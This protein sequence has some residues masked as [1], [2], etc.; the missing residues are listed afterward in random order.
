[1]A[2]V[3]FPSPQSGAHALATD[4]EDDDPSAPGVKMSFLEHLDELRKRIVN[5]VHRDCGLRRGRV[6]LHQPDLSTS[7]W[8]RRA[9]RCPPGVKLIYTQPGEA[10]SLYVQIAL[11]MGVVAR[12]AVHH[13][14][15]VDVHRP[16]PVRE[17]EAV[18]DIHSCSSR[19]SD[20]SRGAAF[21]H[22]VSF[23]FMMA[24][25]ASFNT[26]DLAFMPKLD[27]VFGAVH[28]VAARDGHRLPD[29]DRGVL[30]REDEARLGAV[31]GSAPQVRLADH[32][33]RGGR[34][35]AD[36]RHDDA[37]DLRR[38]DAGPLP[39]SIVIAWVVGPKRLEG[40]DA[41]S[42]ALPLH[43]SAR[44][45][46]SHR[47]CTIM[48]EL[49]YRGRYSLMT[50]ALRSLASRSP[51]ALLCRV[52]DAHRSDPSIQPQPSTPPPST[53][54]PTASPGDDDVLRRHRALVCADRRGP[55]GT[56][57]GRPA[58]TG[59]AR[60]GFR[61]T[62]TSPTSPARSASASRIARRSSAR[63]SSTPASI[64]TSGRSSSRR[65][66]LRR[67]HRPLSAGH[68]GVD[69]RQRR[70]LLRRREDQRL[71]EHRQNPAA[72]ALRGM[73]KL[74]TGKRTS[75]SAPARPTC[76]IDLDRQQGSRDSWSKSPALAATSSAGSR[77]A[78]T[79]RTARS[80]GAAAS[81]S[82]R[83]TSCASSAS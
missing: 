82:R 72:I 1:M 32:L 45:V 53:R 60:T 66:D 81:A 11:I 79:R 55:A 20:S 17:R 47:R 19:R 77:T 6:L 5:S 27:D 8:R 29:A 67:R 34:H 24:F 61:D 48:A 31:P 37:G 71:S 30:P 62:R 76:S 2:L 26:P 7:S 40:G 74:P 16:R 64:A 4:D 70:R 22:Y 15:G 56:A 38:A 41:E 68:A 57:S 43:T 54:A 39:P 83:A 58:C 46:D 51:L 35:H 44:C 65:S 12:R 69:R 52:L 73:V 18:G 42:A 21:N 75:A 23:P 63:S 25:F 59:A 10:F 13:V 49:L 3:P 28:E 9:R 50:T 14:S 33:H 78:S 80:A 36:R